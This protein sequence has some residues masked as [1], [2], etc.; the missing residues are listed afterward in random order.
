MAEV[1]TAV[2]ALAIAALTL[3]LGRRDVTRPAV[4]FGV[5]W[6]GFVAL[7]Q[8]RLTTLETP[9]PA[10]FR[11][12][13]FA[14]GLAFVGAAT[15]AGGTAAVRRDAGVR[16][17]DHRGRPL[18]IAALVL[19]A[20]GV[21]GTAYKAHVLGGLPLLSGEADVVRARAIQGG[22]VVVPAWSTALTNC[23]YLGMWCALLALWVLRG[24]T[25]RVRLAALW[26]LAAGAL[27]GVALLAS[28]NT[29]L[30]AAGIPVICAY[31]IARPERRAARLAWAGLAAGIVVLIVGGLFVA[32]LAER[33][34]QEET[35]LDRELAAQPLVL[36]P[37]VPFYINAVYP[38][39]AASRVYRAV[40]DQ[41]PYTHGAASLT[42]LPDAAFP[43]GKPPFGDD[44][45]VLMR[46][47]EAPGLGWTVAGY[48][49][50]L[51][52][53]AGPA[54]VVLG[55]LLL[56]LGF[57]ALYRWAR[58][59]PGVLPVVLVAYLAYYSAFMVYDN[60]L[61]FTVIGVFDLAVVAAIG[62]LARREGGAPVAEA[63]GGG[64]AAAP[65]TG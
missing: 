59:R 61:S 43:E 44:T 16:R 65:A 37:L 24:R 27:F 19:C 15:L 14:G 33:A 7:A 25:P 50:R 11:L 49:G 22:E 6:F 54:G 64:A 57:G 47:P 51:L 20:C 18:V 42:S 53:D 29:L 12:L 28:R 5:V 55:S 36:K 34:P 4:A 26:A 60:Y 48:E 17:D 63:P 9:W 35:F 30:F 62:A 46:S 56:G 10:G 38:L 58:G 21:A 41:I 2:A 8:L 45:G 31:L 52:A 13:V 23:F 3:F 32:R 39:E 40:P 1:L